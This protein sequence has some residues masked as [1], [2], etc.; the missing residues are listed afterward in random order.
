MSGDKLSQEISNR[1]HGNFNLKAKSSNLLLGNSSCVVVRVQMASLLQDKEGKCP[2]LLFKC[3]CIT[4]PRLKIRG[5]L[6]IHTTH[7]TQTQRTNSPTY[8]HIWD[9]NSKM[10]T[11]ILKMFL[12]GKIMNLISSF[13]QFPFF[14]CYTMKYIYSLLEENN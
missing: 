11:H 10:S 4:N 7:N 12:N 6:Y 3:I 13:C 1:R 2:I 5:G 14:K 9:Q 8:I